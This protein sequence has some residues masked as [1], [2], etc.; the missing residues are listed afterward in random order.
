MKIDWQQFGL[1]TNPYDILPLVEGGDLSLEDAFIGRAK[2]RNFLDDIFESEDRTCLTIC[3]E[4]GVGKT[5]LANVHKYVWKYKK[6]K[7]LFSCRREIE[8]SDTLLNKQSF[9]LEIIGSVLREIKLLQPELLKEDLLLKLEQI[10]D[11]SQMMTIS[12]G[13]SANFSGFG[14]GINFSS[15]KKNS[16]PIK[17]SITSLE[18]H[19]LDLISF[20]KSNS[21]GGRIYRGLILHVNNFDV[22]FSNPRHKNLVTIFFN[23]VRDLLQT[24]DVYFLF[25]GPT[26]FY[27]QVIA[28]E[29]RIK[30]VVGRTP[31][32]LKPLS[33]TE[34]VEALEKRMNLLTSDG[35]KHY[36]KPIDDEVVFRL[37]D[38]YE[39]DI[40]SVMTGIKDI[41][42]QYEERLVQPLST[43]EAMVLLAKERWA[44]IEDE[45]TKEQKKILEFLVTTNR[46]VSGKEISDLLGKKQSNVSGY[47]FPPLKEMGIIEKKEK[48]GA[49]VYYGLT[50]QYHPLKWWFE[51]EMGIRNAINAA[52]SSQPTLFGE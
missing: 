2:E 51:S 47:Y 22:V 52:Q 43:K 14:G 11:I 39:G 41:L 8:A 30:S 4:T 38:L 44:S 45:L 40:R 33:K 28:K 46:N 20:I 16:T 35:V 21:I 7:L 6:K 36:L 50:T 17:L 25:L 49:M 12:G 3:G 32:I 23:E 48:K 26:D 15:D 19:F 29:L 9:L 10:V 27:S 37:Y 42:G 34:V 24:K 5:S 1:R 13:L 18:Q 31:I